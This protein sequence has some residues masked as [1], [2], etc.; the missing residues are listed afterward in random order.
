M[1]RGLSVVLILLFA[2]APASAFWWTFQHRS[3]HHA[4]L[5]LHRKAP[6]CAEI[7]AAVKSL[8]PDRYE[9]ALR[10][11]TEAQQKAIAQCEAHP[12]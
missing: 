1:A 4:H 6:N 2:G 8:P 12:P 10:S 9:R 5:R 11:A 7:N 3:H